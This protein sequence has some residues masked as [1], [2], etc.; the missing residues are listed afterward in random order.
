MKNIGHRARSRDEDQRSSLPR[1]S[2]EKQYRVLGMRACLFAWLHNFYA[3]YMIHNAIL[4]NHLG[5]VVKRPD[6]AIQQI[7][8][9]RRIGDY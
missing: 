4:S 9:I 3:Q 8:A 5:P 2:I 6:N 7:I 1:Q